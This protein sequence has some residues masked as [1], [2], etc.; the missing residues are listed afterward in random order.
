MLILDITNGDL[1]TCIFCPNTEGAFKQSSNRWAHLLCA[2]WIPEVNLGNYA[3]MEPVMDVEK[4]PKS[5]WKLL[6]YICSQPMGACIQCGNRACYKAFHVTCARRCRLY[7]KMKNAHGQLSIID[8][9]PLKAF[10][11]DHCPPDYAKEND[12]ARGYAEA[13]AWYKKNMRG[14]IWAENQES[15]LAIAAT[16]QHAVTEHEPNESQLTGAQIANSTVDGRKTGNQPA[17]PTGKLPSGA[18][19]IPHIIYSTVESSLQRFNIL[20]R[21]EFVADVCA[22]WTLKREQRR[23]APLIK[24][25]QLQNDT[26]SSHEVTRRNYPAMGPIGRER[27]DRRIEFGS[28]VVQDLQKLVVLT[29]GVA[30]REKQKM[31]K[32]QNEKD[33]IE[34]IYFPLIPYITA[35]LDKAFQ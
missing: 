5:R 24:R 15:A 21:K 28:L 10:C 23:G 27:L 6:C 13:R 1:Q 11:H 4:V 22:Y 25:L 7:L 9:T 35:I 20:R 29:S 18:P 26:F 16:H 8:N 32:A 19:V 14:R 33:I 2:M 17:K 30:E 34:N 31:E 12:V 3:F